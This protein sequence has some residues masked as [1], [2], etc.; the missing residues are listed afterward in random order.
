M[1]YQNKLLEKNRARAPTD[2]KIRSFTHWLINETLLKLEAPGSYFTLVHHRP[3]H[4]CIPT[5][6]VS[7]IHH[8][9][10]NSLPPVPVPV[11]VATTK[12]KSVRFCSD[13]DLEQVRLFIKTQTPLAVHSD[14]PMPAK[15]TRL[16]IK[17]PNWPS[18][19][20]MYKSLAQAMIRME[21]V[22]LVENDQG[23]KVLMGRCR[24]ANL[25]FEKQVVVRYS[26]DHWKSYSEIKASFRESLASSSPRSWDRFTFDIDLPATNTAP[27]TCWIALCYHVNQQE[28][29]DN[30]EGKNYQVDLVPISTLS[31]PS[32]PPLQLSDTDEEEEDD[33]D[34]D[35]IKMDDA[36]LYPVK[37]TTTSTNTTSSTPFHALDQLK[38]RYS[39][40]NA[41]PSTTTSTTNINPS[42]TYQHSFDHTL[43]SSSPQLGYQDFISK[44]CFYNSSPP[45]SILQN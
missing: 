22:Q 13:E 20:S 32:T 37:P 19:W 9:Q 30:N 45:S 17:Y 42:L 12:K 29:W 41:P 8:G 15:E 3:K 31:S 44:Y 5:R 36:F 6:R 33:D 39:F 11:P 28:F 16:D 23:N 43:P 38:S 14:P 4:Q 21:N 25:A 24:V 35:D 34:D 7:L 2:P 26:L 18:K 40:S 27:F 1:S 10:A